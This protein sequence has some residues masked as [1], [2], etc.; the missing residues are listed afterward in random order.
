MVLVLVDDFGLCDV[1]RHMLDLGPIHI[2]GDVFN[3]GFV[4]V[5]GDINT[6]F[7]DGGLF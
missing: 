4:Y 5:F 1:V 2:G 7:N 3:F 6:F